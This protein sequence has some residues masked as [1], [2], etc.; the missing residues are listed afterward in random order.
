MSDAGKP[1]QAKGVV[2]LNIYRDEYGISSHSALSRDEEAIACVRVEWAEGEFPAA[3][4]TIDSLAQE[5]GC[6]ATPMAVFRESIRLLHQLEEA[7]DEHLS[8]TRGGSGRNLAD[9]TKK[10][11]TP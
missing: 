4:P 8:G 11:P 1:V 9:A 6:E 3:P 7:T 2:Y 5:L 10:A